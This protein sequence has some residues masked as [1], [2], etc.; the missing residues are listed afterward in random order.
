MFV[1]WKI[2]FPLMLAWA[3]SAHGAIEDY[4][5]PEEWTDRMGPN[6]PTNS[7]KVFYWHKDTAPL[8]KAWVI[9][10]DLTDKHWRFTTRLGK[11]NVAD[12]DNRLA[13][14]KVMAGE[15]E[16]EGR[17]PLAAINGNYFT[18]PQDFKWD[19]KGEFPLIN[20]YGAL[21]S[22][23]KVLANA[24]NST[25]LFV[26]TT[27][28]AF[29]F[30][31]GITVKQGMTTRPKLSDGRKIRNATGFYT[32][33]GVR[34]DQDGYHGP[35]KPDQSD[36]PDNYPR[37]LIGIG[38]GCLVMFVSDGRHDDWS[39]GVKDEDAVAMMV[40]HGC[41]TVAEN[42]G[43][44]SAGMWVKNLPADLQPKY[45]EF[46]N[47]TDSG[48]RTVAEGIFM[49]YEDEFIERVRATE[50]GPNKLPNPYET[51]DEA[52]EVAEAGDRIE[53][54]RPVTLSAS[55]TIGV[56]CSLSTTNDVPE[57]S[58]ITFADGVGLTIGGTVSL[59]N[60]A[61]LQAD[62]SPAPLE[63][64]KGQARVAGKVVAS[65]VHTAFKNDFVVNGELTSPLVVDCDEYVYT[66]K[67]VLGGSIYFGMVGST[68]SEAALEASLPLLR[69]PT[70]DS[71]MAVVSGASGSRLLAWAP[72]V[73][74]INGVNYASL[75]D[76]LRAAA[77]LKNPEVEIVS[78]ARTTQ[79][80][81]LDFDCTITALPADPTTA[82]LI[83]PGDSIKVGEGAH[84]LVKN[85]ALRDDLGNPLPISVA[86][87]GTLS[88][89]G[90]VAVSA[91]KT[92]DADGFELAGPLETPLA[93]SCAT[94]PFIGHAF[95]W[96]MLS[97]EGA[98]FA[99]APIYF[100][101][102]DEIGVAVVEDGGR[103][104]LS[105]GLRPVDDEAAV[106][107]CVT[108]DGAAV[109]YRSLRMLFRLLESD[110]EV[111]LLKDCPLVEKVTIPAGRTV[112]MGSLADA[113]VVSVE[114]N[115]VSWTVEGSLTVTN[116][117]FNGRETRA[118]YNRG[119]TLFRVADGGRLTLGEH[120]SLCNFELTTQTKSG[121]VDI[122]EGG[123]FRME[124]GSSI[125]DC[126]GGDEV[127]G[128]A[129]TVA[130]TF[131]L[132][133]GEIVRCC[134][135]WGAVYVDPSSDAAQVLVSGPA[136]VANNVF[137]SGTFPSD[138]YIQ[139]DNQLQLNGSLTGEVGVY[140][141]DNSELLPP[142]AFGLVAD[143]LSEAAQATASAFFCDD[144]RAAGEDLMGSV[145]DGQLCWEP[146]PV[147]PPP[148]N[149]GIVGGKAYGTLEDA[150]AAAQDGDTLELY[151]PLTLTK[152]VI[153]N[154]DITLRAADP[155]NVISRSAQ[156]SLKIAAGQKV[157]F[158]DIVLG[159]DFRAWTDEFIYVASGATLTLADGAVVRNVLGH[160][161]FEEGSHR[162]LG[163]AASGLAV[164]G[165]LVMLSGAVVSNCVNTFEESYGGGVLVS[166]PGAKFDFRGGL[167][168]GCSAAFGGG[169]CIE[170]QA[171]MSAE[172]DGRIIGNEN[173]N[174]YVAAESP[175]AMTGDFSGC[176]RYHIGVTRADTET[177]IFAT[178]GYDYG[179]DS[180][181]LVRDAA[182][183]TNE[184]T[185][186]VGVAV[187]NEAGEA[188]FAWNTAFVGTECEDQQ[189]VRWWAIGEVPAFVRHVARP[190]A[191]AGLVY[192]GLCQTGVVAVAEGYL[193]SG[194]VATNAGDYTAAAVL[195]PDYI[196]EDETRDVVELAWSIAQATYD[197]RGVSFTNATFVF[198]GTPKSIYISGVLP[199][200]VTNVTYAGNEQTAIG[201]YT[202]TASFWGDLVNYL[203]I[204]DK[205]ATLTIVEEEDPE[206]EE[207][208]WLVITNTPSPIAFR[209]INRL[210]E[211]LWQLVITNREPYCNYRLIWTTDLTKGFVETGA[212]E[213]AVG[214]AAEPVWTTNIVTSGG[215]WFW[216]A[217]GAEGTNMVPVEV[218]Q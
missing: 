60:I 117:V 176:V 203:P 36:A 18:Y 171:T 21:V 206:E 110:A 138:I 218:K 111:S 168:T 187:T 6:W 81:T 199:Q 43:G 184:E 157:T 143:G 46:I 39:Y 115:K 167:V 193:L 135:S 93:V 71:L 95:G 22:D 194:N 101:G 105:W 5:E 163:R 48:P 161:E 75:D 42:D 198:D 212:W 207:P 160:R 211:T 166:G 196:W 126:Q 77:K 31:N 84:V 208:Q 192:N 116:A 113:L 136:V 53:V 102:D 68:V 64:K 195:M 169:V 151:V 100:A 65:V 213:H 174:L 162:A 103:V 172:G 96:T 122:A 24:W 58:A 149:V 165:T 129:V 78:K 159:D 205:C 79:S 124:S 98:D 80:W 123:Y 8:G 202:V 27:D 104:I 180:S 155:T 217:E 139:S 10:F 130:G 128:T 164:Q 183:F 158:E 54:L 146:R 132:A 210:S 185:M 33:P 114:S 2:V 16:K 156:I 170:N 82:P 145:Q 44:G 120:T 72:V 30:Q 83:L 67:F 178:V 88:V 191:V 69:H 142:N 186:A 85:L 140:V 45:T 3:F 144:M 107:R 109:N 70:N 87:N 73:A 197:M 201:S 49:L 134:G 38:D 125:S 154:K 34:Y 94:A 150:L 47:Q 61:F 189:N 137:G 188:A 133:G 86:S 106:A 32:T 12:H 50:S 173:G 121:V 52:L 89:S 108:P 62:G 23:Y 29:S 90:F 179:G 51:I 97:C 63:V 181:V 11:T 66:E 13:T 76:A 19:W 118:F 26:Q 148:A 99:A 141:N 147:P 37:S 41:H 119:T 204:A 25:N 216:R 74:R 112:T 177:N 214:P 91:V 175:L 1:K 59:S 215:A 153:I 182:C 15:L 92:E 131:D 200:G 190:V 7:A 152:T 56:N 9:K 55:K 57:A 209:E 4:G 17:K 14:L 35:A 28:L 40:R 20:L 127:F